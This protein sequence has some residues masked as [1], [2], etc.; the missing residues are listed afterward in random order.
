MEW[1]CIF[2]YDPN[3]PTLC[4]RFHLWTLWCH[5]SRRWLYESLS[6]MFAK[7]SCGYV[8]RGSLSDVRRNNGATFF[9]FWKKEMEDCASMYRMWIW[10]EK[11]S[12]GRWWHGDIFA[13]A[14]EINLDSV[15]Y[16]F[17]WVV[18]L[19]YYKKLS[20]FQCAKVFSVKCRNVFNGMS[21]FFQ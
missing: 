16:F 20:H 4:R 19:L 12:C 11:S 8:S 5:G 14:T 18:E 2:L 10:K 1:N 7:S 9:P 3:F 21:F 15:W 6:K 17:T 13:I